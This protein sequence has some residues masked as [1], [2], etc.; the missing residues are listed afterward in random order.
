MLDQTQPK[1]FNDLVI[2][3]AITWN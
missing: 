3:W 2:I 1:T